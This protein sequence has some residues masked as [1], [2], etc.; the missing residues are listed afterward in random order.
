MAGSSME[1]WFEFDNFFNPGFGQVGD[2]VLLAYE[3]TGGPFGPRDRWIAHR[4]DGTYP[5]GFRDEMAGNREPL[6]QLAG[7]QLAIFD[8]HFSGD[9]AAEQNAFEEFGHGVNFDDRRPNGDKVHKMDAGGP[10]RPPQ[11]YHAWH[12]FIRAVMLLGADEDR[13]LAMD[14]NLGLA[15][16]IQNEAR[17]ADD[18]PNNQPLPPE[19]LD[20][21]R[22]AW[23]KL[24][25]DEL[26]T[27][28]DSTPL[29]PAL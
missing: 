4:A 9:A 27:A 23:L 25:V 22:G 14:R 11:A 3:L 19:R 12:C 2:D 6:M 26:D 8:R 17:P 16:A 1:F 24:D 28:F 18:D 13:W 15:W 10:D 21:L 29:P 5:D 7:Q 20:A